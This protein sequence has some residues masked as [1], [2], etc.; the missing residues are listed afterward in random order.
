[1]ESMTHQGIK[2]EA[3]MLVCRDTHIW[4]H[5]HTDLCVAIL[6][7]TEHAVPFE[8]LTFSNPEL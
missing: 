1:M 2:A 8:I 3:L 6:V 4:G 5:L 7:G